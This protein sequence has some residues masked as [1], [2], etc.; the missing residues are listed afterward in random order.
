MGLCVVVVVSKR[1]CAMFREL[2][3]ESKQF[4]LLGN[5]ISQSPSPDMHNSAFQRIGL[6]YT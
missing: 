2:F 1:V 5:P 3:L 4:F 6:P